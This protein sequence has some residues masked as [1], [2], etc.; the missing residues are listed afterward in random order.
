MTSNYEVKDCIYISHQNRG[1]RGPDRM[2]ID[3]QL[4]VQSVFIPT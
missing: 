1:R 2:V 4:P 3:L